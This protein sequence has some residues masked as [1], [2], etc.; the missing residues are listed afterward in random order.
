MT[1]RQIDFAVNAARQLISRL[2]TNQDRC[3]LATFDHRFSV[4]QDFTSDEPLLHRQLEGI[5]R[6]VEDGGTRLYDSI[7]DAVA[8]FRRRGDGRRPWVL[9]VVTDGC[10]GC[11]KTYR[12]TTCGQHVL[13]EYNCV[14]NNFV[15]VVGVGEGVNKTDLN[16]MHG[17]R[18]RLLGHHHRRLSAARAQVHAARL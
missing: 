8:H 14:D 13:R 3:C 15:Y 1:N 17:Q 10:D 16:A 6:R 7:A 9:I 11:S 2:H 5:R 18:G 4:V 12:A